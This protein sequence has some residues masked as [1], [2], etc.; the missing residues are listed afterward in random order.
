M[1]YITL[2]FT[3]SLLFW[4]YI[5]TADPTKLNSEHP[6]AVNARTWA[7]GVGSASGQGLC[8]SF[9]GVVRTLLLLQR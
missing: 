1:F 4:G 8:S 7:V 3:L 5:L 2:G 6:L 9:A